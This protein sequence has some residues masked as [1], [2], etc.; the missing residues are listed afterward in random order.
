MAGAPGVAAGKGLPSA[1]PGVDSGAAGGPAGGTVE[2]NTTRAA[3]PTVEVVATTTDVEPTNVA[4]TVTT[5]FDTN[6]DPSVGAEPVVAAGTDLPNPAPNAPT[7]PPA[8]A[9]APP[10]PT[11]TADQG[12]SVATAE[13]PGSV[14]TPEFVATPDELTLLP[15]RYA[16][17]EGTFAETSEGLRACLAALG[18][19]ASE[20]IEVALVTWANE[21]AVL[22][23]EE[24]STGAADQTEIAVWVVGTG[25]SAADTQLR[26]ASRIAR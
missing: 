5:L 25:C 23:A 26:W 3:V 19:P 20:R 8:P 7:A 18:A 1:N 15:A 16:V 22:I 6:A 11:V 9:P 2:A 17:A 4:S 24:I 13:D 12:S 10:E 14:A 21:P